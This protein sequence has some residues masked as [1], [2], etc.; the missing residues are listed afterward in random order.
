[1]H[2]VFV[3]FKRERVCGALGTIDA[4]RI[5]QQIR[6]SCNPMPASAANCGPL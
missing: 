3:G 2:R 4:A 6:E 1:M 5:L